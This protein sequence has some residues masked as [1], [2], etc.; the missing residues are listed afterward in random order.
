[1]KQRGRGPGGPDLAPGGPGDVAGPGPDQGGG[2]E[3][4]QAIFEPAE[5][6][7]IA[8]SPA[9]IVVDER[10]GR[11]RTLHPDGRKRKAENGTAEIK[12]EWKEGK[13]TVETRSARR[14]VDESWEL[15]ATGSR[16]F[17]SV[18]L[19]GGFGPPLSLKRVY[20]RTP[21]AE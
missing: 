3:A 11:S 19:A 5:E 12:A 8:Q 14:K 7:T 9:E 6:L 4:V 17:L 1:M 16:L 20:D 10:F 13:L 21:A 18:K 2:G 15:S